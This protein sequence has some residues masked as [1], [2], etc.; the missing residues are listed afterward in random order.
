M[1]KASSPRRSRSPVRMR[2]SDSLGSAHSSNEGMSFLSESDDSIG[3]TGSLH[4]HGKERRRE[5]TRRRQREE[6]GRIF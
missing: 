2:R 3:S 1:K 5:R 4:R 6:S